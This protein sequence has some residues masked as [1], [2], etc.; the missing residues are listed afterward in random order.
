VFPRPLFPTLKRVQD[1]VRSPHGGYSKPLQPISD[2][3]QTDGIAQ[4]RG[5]A[6]KGKKRQQWLKRFIRVLVLPWWACGCFAAEERAPRP[7]E[8]PAT[9]LRRRQQSSN[10]SDYAS[11]ANPVPTVDSTVARIEQKSFLDVQRLKPRGNT[12]D[13]DKVKERNERRRAM[14]NNSQSEQVAGESTTAREGGNQNEGS[15]STMQNGS[16]SKSSTR[17]K[18][19]GNIPGRRP[20]IQTDPM[21]NGAGSGLSRRDP[22]LLSTTAREIGAPN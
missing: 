12:G 15:S 21:V 2:N 10:D 19:R 6:N 22:A 18:D 11:K 5:N 16:R 7:R 14:Q 8:V 17:K 1:L 4:R 13:A 20:P 3:R 9:F